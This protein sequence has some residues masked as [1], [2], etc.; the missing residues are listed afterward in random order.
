M[1]AWIELHDGS[2]VPLGADCYFGRSPANTIQLHA[3]SASRRHA[4][5]HAQGIEGDVEH[6]L[7][8]LGSTNGTLCNGRRIIIPCRLQDGDA[9]SILGET[10]VFRAEAAPRTAL[11]FDADMPATVVVRDRQDCWMLM[12]DVKRYTALSHQLDSDTLSLKVG[13]WLRRC[14]DAVEAAG[15][16]VDKFLGDAIFVYWKQSSDAPALVAAAIGKLA[17]IQQ[18][19]DLD[20]RIVLHYGPANVTGGSGGADNVSGP[21]VIWAFRMEKVC[22]QLGSDSLVSEAARTVLPPSC[23]CEPLGS[24]PLDGFK[25]TYPMHQ[26]VG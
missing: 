3:P 8:D 24:F 1:K 5:I 6:W 15:G 7:V 10:F 13:T 11:N 16:V 22:S 17:A 2:T 21:E 4:H 9:I 25:G 18:Q 12:L 20:F 14:R 23:Q 19:R 26:L